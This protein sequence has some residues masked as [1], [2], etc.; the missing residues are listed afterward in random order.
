MDQVV[1]TKPSVVYYGLIEAMEAEVS[2]FPMP[3]DWLTKYRFRYCV[4]AYGHVQ[5]DTEYF[6]SMRDARGNAKAIALHHGIKAVQ[7]F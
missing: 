7:I 4:M 3:K 6:T 1:N 2:A 5:F